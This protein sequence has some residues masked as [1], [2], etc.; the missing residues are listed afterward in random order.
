M[1]V[2]NHRIDEIWHGMTTNVSA[3]T[4]EPR[5]LVMHYTT[6]WN[7]GASRDWLM[8]RA[9][10]TGNAGSSAH[11]VIDRDGTAWQ[12]C[13]FNRA[14][15]HAGPSRWSG[16]EGLN[17]HSIGF[18][19]VNPGVLKPDGPGRWQD[20]F[21]HRRTTDELEAFGGFVEARNARVGGA[22]YAWPRY[23]DAQ[24]ETGLEIAAAL[25]ETYGIEAVLSHEEIDTRGWKTDPGPAFPMGAFRALVERLDGDGAD[26]R[27]E[28]TATRL[29]LRAG[30]GAGFERIEPPGSLPR[31][32]RVRILRADA[33]WAF[34]EVVGGGGVQAGI[35]GWLH[36]D[37]LDRVR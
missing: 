14:S 30:A 29:N 37:Y 4:I 9:G 21:N 15:W 16:V 13:P 6:G 19:F 12:I 34:A 25:V 35:T 17:R 2:R 7:G 22:S 10:G 27:F 33:E 3:G 24:I 18:E 26:E 31:G 32:T 36:R 20:D 11:L 28:V 23:T 5:F 1:K 8:G